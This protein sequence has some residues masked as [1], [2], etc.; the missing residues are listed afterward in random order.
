M[1]ESTRTDSINVTVPNSV[2][3]NSN[4]IVHTARTVSISASKH[5]MEVK[6]APPP[7]TR[8]KESSTTNVNR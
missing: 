8:N 1:V 6:Y 5:D 2:V 4:S 7:Q 3:S